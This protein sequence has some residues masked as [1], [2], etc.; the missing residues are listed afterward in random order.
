MTDFRALDRI[1]NPTSVAIVGVSPSRSG[2]SNTG[3][4]FL[5]AI[6]EYGFKGR[7]YPIYPGGG[8]VAGLK[9]YPSIRDVPEPVDYV[10]S[11]VS[12]HHVLQLIR[13]CADSGAKGVCLFTAG[14]SETGRED[15]AGLE[16]E[17]SLLAK[18]TGVRVI[19]PNCLGVYSPGAGFSFAVDF[20]KEG[21]RV[22]L[23]CQ[24]GGNSLY[25][26]R[27]A[28]ER[29]VRFSK[30][31]SYGNACDIGEVELLEYFTQDAET[32]IVAVYIEGVKDGQQFYRAIRELAT[33]KPVV[34]LKGGCT[35]A[36]VVVAASHTGSMAGSDEVWD[37]LLEQ[38]GVIRVHSLD[39]MVD[40]MVTFQFMPVP[41][42]RR[43]MVLGTGGGA[44]VLATDHCAAAGFSLPQIPEK[45]REELFHAIGSDVGNILGNPLDIVPMLDSDYT[46]HEVLRRVLGWNGIDLLLYHVPL[47]G[48]MLT[49]PVACFLFD[50]QLG[51]VVHVAGESIKPIAVVVHY[52]SS[53]ESWQ[54]ASKYVRQCYE[55]GLPVYYSAASAVKAIDRLLRYHERRRQRDPSPSSQ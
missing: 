32:E 21:G 39:E 24:S 6:L 54:A 28:G 48:V 38:A 2:V 30:V 26:V 14:F 43:L 25:P 18:A 12:S 47:R 22:G 35:E 41:Q 34:V 16:R 11:C 4:L 10:L 23:I 55:A 50:S 27:A 3:Q 44:G 7:V 31:I 52:L 49:L 51:N 1:F 13:D 53:G 37:G 36:G 20:P 17:I 40:M 15:A 45:M 9:V 46:Y 8:E 33:V 5:D 19:G 42:G 29:G